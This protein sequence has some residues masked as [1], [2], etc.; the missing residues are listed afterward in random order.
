[1]PIFSRNTP[2]SICPARL[3]VSLIELDSLSA[4]AQWKIDKNGLEAELSRVEFAGPEAAG[5]AQGVYRND[6]SGGPGYVDLTAAL[7]RADARAVWRYMPRAVGDGARYWL[8]DSILAGK[9]PEAK[10][11]LK[12]NLDDFPFLDKRKGLFLVDRQSAGRGA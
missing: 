4:R 2:V 9:S 3:P 10:L 12:G 5:S 8:R 7:T 1:M 11:I 6:G